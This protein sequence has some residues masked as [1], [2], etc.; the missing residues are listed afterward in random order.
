MVHVGGH[1]LEAVNKDLDHGA[2][3][4]IDVLGVDAVRLP[5]GDHPVQV[6]RRPPFGHGAGGG[7]ALGGQRRAGLFLQFI[8]ALDDAADAGGLE[9][10]VGDGGEKPLDGEAVALG[11]APQLVGME[12]QTLQA[13]EQVILQYRYLGFLAADAGDVAAG[14]VCRLFALITEHSHG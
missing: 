2:D 14:A 13:V 1:P 5:L 7:G 10:H 6:F 11:I 9:I 12:R 8:A 3:V 4:L